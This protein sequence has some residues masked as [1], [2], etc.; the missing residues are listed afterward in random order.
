MVRQKFTN[1]NKNHTLY[2]DSCIYLFPSSCFFIQIIKINIT[3]I[4][5]P[6]FVFSFLIYSYIFIFT[7]FD[8][9]RNLEYSKIS[10]LIK[11]N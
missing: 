10:K 11:I 1:K 6:F 4:S 2:I 7:K 5:D 8:S 3:I 9:I